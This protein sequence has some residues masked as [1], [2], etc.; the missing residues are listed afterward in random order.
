MLVQFF[1]DHLSSELRI[2]VLN[3]I[4][5]RK[6]GNPSQK[7]MPFRYDRVRNAADSFSVR[8]DNIRGK[9]VV[10]V[11]DLEVSG[12]TKNELRRVFYNKGAQLVVF[13]TL[14]KTE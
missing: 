5:S 4:L 10:L 13:V 9:V 12:A 1:I 6:V 2:P 3:G 11:D 14:A 7:S 8:A